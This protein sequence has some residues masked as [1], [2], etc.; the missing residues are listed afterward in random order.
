[1]RR[2]HRIKRLQRADQTGGPHACAVGGVRHAEH[3]GRNR[4]EHGGGQRRRQP[5]LRATHDVRELQ[6]RG[7]KPLREQAAQTVVPI[8]GGGKAHHLA[9]AADTGR[10]CGDAVD[11]DGHTDGGGGDRSGQRQA[12]DDR[13]DDAHGDGLQLR[14]RVDKIAKIGHKRVDARPGEHAHQPAGRDGGKRRNHDIDGRLAGHE[15]ADFRADHGAQVCA[16]RAAERIAE[17]ARRRR[18]KQHERPHLHAPG[19]AYADRR[20]GSG[21]DVR[22]GVHER[23]CA[24]KKRQLE[25]LPKDRAD[26][27][28]GKQAERHAAHRIDEITLKKPFHHGKKTAFPLH[29]PITPHRRNFNIS[30]PI[31]FLPRRQPHAGTFF[32]I[33]APCGLR[34]RFGV[35]QTDENMI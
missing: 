1:M 27:E 17:R 21:A 32:R 11:T 22:Q 15:R 29:K 13:N 34:R 33:R 30:Y 6:H 23:L 25:Q 7:A 2:P 8:G 19:H 5:D 14:C 16:D 4:P 3:G 12:D 9:T 28:R 31:P 24:C 20:A 35:A 18:G 10:S 26:D